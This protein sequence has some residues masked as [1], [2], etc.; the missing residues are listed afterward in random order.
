MAMCRIYDQKIHSRFDQALSASNSAAGGMSGFTEAINGIASAVPGAMAQLD[1]LYE[2]MAS[3][4]NS[5]IFKSI[6]EWAA[7]NG[8]QNMSG[9][10]PVSRAASDT[11]WS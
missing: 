4:G 11:I 6:N 9:V 3:I 7:R 8:L 1:S 5:D 10:T 2:K